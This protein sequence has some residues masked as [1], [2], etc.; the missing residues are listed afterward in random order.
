VNDITA[1][2]FLVAHTYKLYHTAFI[3]MK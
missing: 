2:Q 3:F 1:Q